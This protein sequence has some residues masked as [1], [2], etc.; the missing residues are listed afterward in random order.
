MAVI[1]SASHELGG[2]L[3]GMLFID[4]FGGEHDFLEVVMNHLIDFIVGD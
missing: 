4:L 1:H 2:V 3:G